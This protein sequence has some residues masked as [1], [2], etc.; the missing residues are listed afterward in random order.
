MDNYAICYITSEL[1]ITR[2]VIREADRQWHQR[3]VHASL[4]DHFNFT[5]PCGNHCPIHLAEAQK[6]FLS[7]DRK[8]L[9][10]D[11]S[12]PLINETLVHLDADPFNLYVKKNNE[13]CTVKYTGPSNAV[14]LQKDKCIYALNLKQPISRDL[15][16]S[17]S[18]GCKPHTGFPKDL[19]HFSIG[20]CELQHPND[21]W[22][23]VKV[24]PY[25]GNYHVYCAGSKISIEG[26]EEDCPENVF[27]L[28][29]SAKFKI[30]RI[31]YV[32]SKIAIEHDQNVGKIL[33]RRIRA[34]KLEYLL[35]W[36][37]Y[38]D[39][40]NTWEPKE[41]IGAAL[42]LDFELE[43]SKKSTKPTNEEEPSTRSRK[44]VLVAPTSPSPPKKTVRKTNARFTS[45][46]G[47]RARDIE[48]EPELKTK[49]NK[50]MDEVNSQSDF[51]IQWEGKDTTELVPVSYAK[52]I[53]P[54]QTIAFYEQ[55]IRW[56]TKTT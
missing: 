12:A 8:K 25:Q 4:L 43:N 42:I 29:Y 23:F 45:V 56:Q 33:K 9:Y 21:E 3:K 20:H 53:W 7:D 49:L 22:G 1:L 2:D 48:S 51:K 46:R 24:K 31:E 54:Q 37:G 34:V 47:Q 10:M 36:K 11:F 41:N 40:D 14:M 30:N 27:I 35:K 52:I 5:M 26:R 13:T 50:D 28:P 17:P 16:V 19:K 6:C 18:R 39:E 44:S 32:G 38:G 55:R 15:I